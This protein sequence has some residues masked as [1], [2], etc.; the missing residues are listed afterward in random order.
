MTDEFDIDLVI[1]DYT[2]LSIRK[3]NVQRSHEI[4]KLK[5]MSEF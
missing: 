5:F 3:G 2:G 4:W 1:P